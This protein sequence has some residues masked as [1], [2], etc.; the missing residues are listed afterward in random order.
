[1]KK[2]L[3]SA[4]KS[5]RRKGAAIE[6]AVTLLVVTFSLSTLILTTSFLAHVRQVKAE[7]KVERQIVF[8]QIGAE[9][10]KGVKTN[11]GTAWTNDYPD[12]DI[13]VNQLA[14]SVKEKG[15]EE[16]LFVAE[17]NDNGDGTYNIIKWKIN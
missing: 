13:T 15:E 4:K 8:E 11:T 2:H 14:L 6:L 16:I 3:F 10:I 1:M 17:L 7:E 12:Y 9:F 5:N